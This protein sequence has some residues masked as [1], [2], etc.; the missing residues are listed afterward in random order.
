M[1]RGEIVVHDKDSHARATL[2]DVGRETQEYSDP[3]Q[4]KKSIPRRRKTI[5]CDFSGK[6]QE[7]KGPLEKWFEN[8]VY[9]ATLDSSL[10]EKNP[11]SLNTAGSF[12]DDH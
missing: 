3:C 6:R 10:D 4:A 7:L 12:A 2:R 5:F 1:S 9:D 11:R 8:K